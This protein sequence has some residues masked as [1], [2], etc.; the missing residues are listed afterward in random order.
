MEAFWREEGLS[1]QRVPCACVQVNRKKSAILALREADKAEAKK[2]GLLALLPLDEEPG[3]E[4]AP[5]WDN[6]VAWGGFMATS[7]NLRYQLV[8]GIEDRILVRI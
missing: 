6:S 8:N 3:K 2:N 5:V 1:L 7:A 4:L